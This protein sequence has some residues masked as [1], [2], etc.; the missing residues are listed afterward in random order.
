MAINRDNQ[1]Y[2]TPIELIKYILNYDRKWVGN[3]INFLEPSAGDGAICREVKKHYE[4]KVTIHCIEIEKVLRDS[5]KGQGFKVVGD[6]FEEY[7]SIPFYDLIIMNPPFAKGAKFLLKAYGLLNG[8]GKIICILNAET[9]K[10][11]YSS[12]RKQLINLIEKVNG[13]VRYKSNC[14][15]DID[16]EI[17]IVTLKK[18]LYET[19]FD[20]FGG[21]Q[22]NVITEEEKIVEELK[23]EVESRG[24]IKFDE[25][26]RAISIYRHCV[27]QLFTGINVIDEIKN[28]LKHIDE[29]TK[30]F[31][32]TTDD[33]MKIILENNKNDAKEKS[34]KVIRFMIW[35]YVT[36]YCKMDQYLFTKQKEEFRKML[37][38]GSSDLPFTR[39]NIRQFFNNIFL[40]RDEYFKQGVEDLFNKITSYH[41]GNNSHREGWKTNKNWKINKK[42]IVNWGISFSSY[43]DDRFSLSYSGLDWMN[44]LDKIVRKIHGEGLVDRGYIK[45][46]LREKFSSLGKVRKGTSYDNTCETPFFHIKFY[47]KGSLHITFRDDNILNKLNMM[48]AQL[49]RDLGYDDYGKTEV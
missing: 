34:I 2:P 13:D 9:I 12:G 1:Y 10:N 17:A 23:A 19:E 41:H 15:K 49:R 35:T 47:K 30:E 33:F 18:P 3:E 26:D 40:K 36:K 38:K 42:I 4:N 22:S 31:N 21:I 43:G 32:I 29:E 25:L 16:V 7:H 5:L 48:G 46:E 45:T 37:D 27:K 44:D 39:D 24:L 28:G 11:A 20:M 6:N 8:G 14:F